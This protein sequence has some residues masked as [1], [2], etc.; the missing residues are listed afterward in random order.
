M[1]ITLSIKKA[2]QVKSQ[3]QIEKS[4]DDHPVEKSRKSKR[5]VNNGDNP[6]TYRKLFWLF[7]IGSVIG[8]M[9]EGLFCLISKGAWETHVVSVYLPL[10]PL[11]G[12]GAVLLYVGAVRLR[13]KNIWCRVLYMTLG[14]T[15]LELI[16]G[17]LLR[18]G[19]GM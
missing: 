6:I 5:D 16:C 3:K 4:A 15:A 1:G 19:L 14:A 7:L 10:N 9:L 8:V 18:Y 11:Y 13:K 2:L 17:L 12:T